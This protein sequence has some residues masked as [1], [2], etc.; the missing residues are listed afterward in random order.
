[1]RQPAPL[2]AAPR[3]RL[4]PRQAPRCRGVG[5]ARS[6]RAVGGGGLSDWSKPVKLTR[7]AWV[8]LRMEVREVRE[9]VCA[10]RSQA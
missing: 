4:Q 5:E 9:D 6:W 2:T 7:A 8:R 1:M 3:L 10:L